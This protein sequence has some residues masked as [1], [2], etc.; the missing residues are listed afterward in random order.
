M[1]IG[2]W[3][4][5]NGPLTAARPVARGVTRANAL[6]GADPP[7]HTFGRPGWRRS[8]GANGEPNWIVSGLTRVGRAWTP[9]PYTQAKTDDGGPRRPGRSA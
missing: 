5:T 1:M 3:L 9:D 2:F 7:S 6:T 4:A 8:S